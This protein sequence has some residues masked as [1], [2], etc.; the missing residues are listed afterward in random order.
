AFVAYDGPELSGGS[1]MLR[2]RTGT[3]RARLDDESLTEIRLAADQHARI[4]L[5]I[6]NS[7]LDHGTAV[8]LYFLQR[9]GWHGK[10][11]ALGYSFLSN[12]DHLR[13][14]KCVKQAIEKLQ[15]PVA[16]I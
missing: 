13:F 4:T 9:N 6:R 7:D 5:R 1:A 15:R 14:G 10:V 11:V 12:E 2:A 8:P 3:D 16:F